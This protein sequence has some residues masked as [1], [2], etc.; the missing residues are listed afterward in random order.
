MAVPGFQEMFLPF[1]KALSDGETRHH[2]E[3]RD[4]PVA[5]MKI[6]EQDQEEMIPS[7]QSTRLANRVGWARTHLGKA[8]LIELKGGGNYQITEAGLKLSQSP[9]PKLNLKF[10][11]TIPQHRKWFHAPKKDKPQLTSE[12]SLSRDTPPN[13][14]IEEAFGE[15]ND[16]LANDLQE[17]LLK[18]SPYRFEKIVIDLLFAMGYGGSREEA[19]KVTKASGDGGIDGTINEDRLGLDIIYVQAK[20]YQCSVPI[21]HVR[22]FAGALLGKRAKKGVFITTSDFPNSARE[23]VSH[24]DQKIILIDGIRLTELM[25]E[26]QVGVSIRQTLHIKSIDSDYFEEG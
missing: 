16:T 14:L 8:G 9:P 3:I 20:R 23:F 11:D 19:A 15:L 24:I 17:R 1:L 18:T 13:E 25:I 2:S 26:H 12:N 6:S 21:A 7:G 5:V 22:D 10:L 4:T